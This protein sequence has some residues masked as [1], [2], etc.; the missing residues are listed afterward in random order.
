MLGRTL[1]IAGGERDIPFMEE[2]LKNQSFDTI[3]CADS[4]LE[5]AWQLSLPVDYVMGDFDSVSGEVLERVKNQKTVVDGQVKFIQHPPEKDATD[6]HLVLEWV[7]DHSPEEIVILGATGRRLDHFLANVNILMIP[8][9]QEIPAYV[10]DKHN[11]LYLLNR[12]R[13]IFREEMYGKYISF[14]PLTEEVRKVCLWG[15]RY[16]L[17]GRDMVIGD[18]LG[19][20]NEMGDGKDSAVVEF[21]DGILIAIE[22]RD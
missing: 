10:V 17:D 2:Y 11:K 8:L 19:V 13:K 6:L 3:A 21:E 1:I 16:E 9:S 15:F 14:L 5:A 4:G 22:S 12:S 20:S 18:S 7:V